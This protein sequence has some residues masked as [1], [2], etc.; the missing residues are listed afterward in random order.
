MAVAVPLPQ[1]LHGHHGQLRAVR[2]PH[3]QPAVR[4]VR[5]RVNPAEH[6]R[7]HRVSPTTTRGTPAAKLPSRS[8]RTI[9]RT[10]NARPTAASSVPP[11]RTN[12]LAWLSVKAS[13]T[14]RIKYCAVMLGLSGRLGLAARG[15]APGRATDPA[16]C[17]P[18]VASGRN[19]SPIQQPRYDKQHRHDNDHKLQHEHPGIRIIGSV[20]QTLPPSHEDG[21]V[22]QFAQPRPAGYSAEVRNTADRASRTVSPSPRASSNGLRRQKRSTHVPQVA[23]ATSAIYE[24]GT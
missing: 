1:Q 16:R 12:G 5:Q 19:P 3:F 17:L 23:Q 24:A 22:P 4:P 14:A 15:L 7:M 20:I 10:M 13:T 21:F 18:N 2:A 11:A 9:E 6:R 8:A